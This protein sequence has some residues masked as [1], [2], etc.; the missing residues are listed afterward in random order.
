MILAASVAALAVIP[1]AAFAQPVTGQGKPTVPTIAQLAAF[2]K[3][4]NVVISPDGKH[5]AAIEGR[6]ED[7][8]ILVWNTDALNQ[9]PTV[10]GSS[11]M[12]INGFDFIKNDRLR[13]V[14]WQPYDFRGEGVTKSFI[15]KLYITDLEGKDWREAITLPR[16]RT[17]QEEEEQAVSSPTVLSKMPD[18]P[19]HILV[20]NSAG[21]NQGDIFKVDI[22]NGRTERI[23]RS[24]ERVSGYLADR[25]GNLRSR[26]KFDSDGNGAFTAVQFRGAD[27]G[28]SE[29]FRSY[30][31]DRDVTDVVG[32]IE[33]PN[34]AIIAT[35]VGTDLTTL[36]EYDIAARKRGEQL[37]KHRYFNATGIRTWPY[38]DAQGLRF[39]E[40]TGVV[41]DGPRGQDTV[42]VAPQMKAIDQ[43]IRTALKI[44]AKPITFT[45]TAT[46]E[47]APARYDTERSVGI[48]DFTPDLKTVIFTDRDVNKPSSYYLLH[49]GQVTMLG[50]SYPD[51]DGRVFGTTSFTYYKARDGRTIPAILTKPNE[52][53]CGAGPWRTVI[54]PHGGPWARDDLAFDNFMWVPMLA[55]R[56]M[57]VMRPQYRGSEGWGRSLWKSGDAEWGGKMQDDKDDGVKWLID[58]KVADPAHVAMFGFSYGGY[59]SMTASVRPNGL[60]K[61]AISGGGVSDIR[62]IF[63]RFYT[64]PFYRQSQAPT[65]KGLS[66]V[67]KA[68]EI[69]IPIMTY[70][71][72]RDQTTPAYQ[73]EIFVDAAK[74]SSQPVEFHLLKDFAHGPAWTRAVNQQ[75]LQLI[76]DYF[77]KGC[78]GSGL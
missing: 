29:H 67:D 38:K 66:P 48:L 13:V 27:G 26:L 72:D 40:I 78:G 71:G 34:I 21:T 4:A 59:A 58:Q 73:T 14:L 24:E 6:G 9:K 19:D 49:N 76:D 68:S 47:S 77:S 17:A 35:N 23:Q 25:E 22:R 75:Q 11:Q 18:D 43:A 10:I 8:V 36:Y 20:V 51:M 55:S 5:I 30:A 44:E 46:G 61:C 1:A 53:L 45:D 52:V 33:D 39:N 31:K 64:N 70:V 74:R 50:N 16:A 28:W 62:K 63:A 60:Y 12:K 56:C 2:P 37:F 32:F 69:K 57:A 54:M 42:W 41:F 15:S 65:V 7:R 3:L